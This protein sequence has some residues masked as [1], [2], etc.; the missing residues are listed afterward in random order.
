[1]LR[2]ALDSST[3]YLVP[4]NLVQCINF[5]YCTAVPVLCTVLIAE[6]LYGIALNCTARTAH[7]C[8]FFQKGVLYVLCFITFITNPIRTEQ[9]AKHI[10]K[11][12]K[13][14]TGMLVYR[15]T[16]TWYLVLEVLA[17]YMRRT[18]MEY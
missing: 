5:V 9:N 4:L 11:K 2:C 12:P 7:L 10:I 13:E 17:F 3:V 1:M 15:I 8:F 6:L 16:I 18:I 14:L